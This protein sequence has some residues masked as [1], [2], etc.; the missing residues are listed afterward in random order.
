MSRFFSDSQ[1]GERVVVRDP[2]PQPEIAAPTREPSPAPNPEPAP[3]LAD[4]LK[5][6]FSSVP[7]RAYRAGFLSARI[8]GRHR[9]GPEQAACA[10]CGERWPCAPVELVELCADLFKRL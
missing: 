5:T 2:H 7:A 6:T 8:K 10:L 1:E 3:R 9:A 4:M